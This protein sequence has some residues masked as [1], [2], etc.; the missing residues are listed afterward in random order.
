[1]LVLMLPV[2]VLTSLL[3]ALMFL[4]LLNKLPSKDS[5]PSLSSL[6]TSKGFSYSGHPS[7]TS[8][9][10]YLEK[11]LNR[12]SDHAETSHVN[13]LEVVEQLEEKEKI[14]T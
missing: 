14:G 3:L 6:D 13:Y 8:Q 11:I 10:D 1:M 4:Q 12:I 5:I 7:E 9:F 2:L